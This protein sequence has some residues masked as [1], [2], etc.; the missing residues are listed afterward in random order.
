MSDE[1]VAFSPTDSQPFFKGTGVPWDISY[2]QTGSI[3]HVFPFGIFARW[4]QIY[5][6]FRIIVRMVLH[7]GRVAGTQSLTA[8]MPLKCF[9]DRI[10]RLHS[11]VRNLPLVLTL[12]AECVFSYEKTQLVLSNL[13]G[14]ISDEQNYSCYYTNHVVR[15]IM[16]CCYTCRYYAFSFVLAS[17]CLNWTYAVTP[18]SAVG[19]GQ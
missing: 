16:M 4:S 12:E 3:P 19:P 8:N 13:G 14:S 15:K 6:V 5:E 2:V 18:Y 9:L 1:F 7:C 10:K 11:I 17:V